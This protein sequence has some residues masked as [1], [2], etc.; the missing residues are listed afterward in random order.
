MAADLRGEY[1]WSEQQETRARFFL[2]QHRESIDHFLPTLDH[3]MSRAAIMLGWLLLV[4]ILAIFFLREGEHICDGII[5]LFFA[6][7]RRSRVRAIAD[8]LHTMLSRYMRAQALL[9][10]FSFLF[11]SAALFTLRFP[12]AIPLALMGGLLEFVPAAGW[13]TTFVVIVGVGIVNHSHWVWMAALL[14]IWRIIQDY[15][16]MP[17]IMGHELKIHPLGAIFAVLV[18]AELGGVVGV[19]LAIPAAAAVRVLWRMTAEG[20][21]ESG[22]HERED[23]LGKLQPVLMQHNS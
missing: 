12:G 18:G 19:Y 9:C 8:E 6:P 11:Y 16:I 14:G 4:P 21:R 3:Y 22:H 10:A 20:V 7:G 1:G 15:M 17:R 5:Q 13:T 23:A 2:V